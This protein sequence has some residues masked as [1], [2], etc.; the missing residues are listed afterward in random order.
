[1]RYSKNIFLN[2]FEMGR[3]F[4]FSRHTTLLKIPMASQWTNSTNTQPFLKSV[5]KLAFLIIDCKTFSNEAN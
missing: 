4:S 1:V 3:V 5:A 2:F